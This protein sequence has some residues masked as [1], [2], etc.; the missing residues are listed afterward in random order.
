MQSLARPSRFEARDDVGLELSRR[1]REP[2]CLCASFG[3]CCARSRSRV[4]GRDRRAVLSRQ[5]S[6]PGPFQAP[7]RPKGNRL[8]E[9]LPNSH[10]THPQHEKQTD[11]DTQGE[12]RKPV[13][14]GGRAWELYVGSP[15]TSSAPLP[16]PHPHDAP[17]NS[18]FLQPT[19]LPRQPVSAQWPPLPSDEAPSSFSRALIEVA[20]RP[21]S[22]T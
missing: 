7:L 2:A 22:R 6:R 14:E 10:S 20:S 15:T 1:A 9:G 21:R 13:K 8:S 3:E 17:E 5:E 16:L 19:S 4:E 12:K 11:A 18:T